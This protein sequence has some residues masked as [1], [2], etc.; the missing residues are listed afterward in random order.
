MCKGSYC[1]GSAHT[2]PGSPKTLP[3]DCERSS[4]VWHFVHA[5]R[6]D[7]LAAH[8]SKLKVRFSRRQ[9]PSREWKRWPEKTKRTD[10]PHPHDPIRSEIDAGSRSRPVASPPLAAPPVL[11]P[12]ARRVA[13]RWLQRVVSRAVREDSVGRAACLVKRG[14]APGVAAIRRDDLKDGV[15]FDKQFPAIPPRGSTRQR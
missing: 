11:Q 8:G 9:P 10:V 4:P 1:S 13:S 6:K 3:S 15:E 7:S 2:H 12:A 14:S 5:V